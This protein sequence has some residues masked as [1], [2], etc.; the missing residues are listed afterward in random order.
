MAFSV[1]GWGGGRCG[2]GWLPGGWGWGEQ[3]GDVVAEEVFQDAGSAGVGLGGGGGASAD[4]CVGRGV[5][6]CR[7]GDGGLALVTDQAQGSEGVPDGRF[8]DS[9]RGF[10]GGGGVFPGP[11]GQAEAGGGDA[12][13]VRDAGEG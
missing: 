13:A 5:R 1:V 8:G 11:G 9:W 12:Q 2:A 10:G 4:R 3:F 7:S 6:A